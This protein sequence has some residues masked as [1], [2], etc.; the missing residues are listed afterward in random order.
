MQVVYLCVHCV[1]QNNNKHVWT[2]DLVL[3]ETSAFYITLIRK[4]YAIKGI[5]VKRW[6]LFKR[7]FSLH[8]ITFMCYPIN[9]SPLKTSSLTFMCYLIKTFKQISGKDRRPR[10]QKWHKDTLLKVVWRTYHLFF[11]IQKNFSFF[12]LGLN[13]ITW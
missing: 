13:A 4:A 1:T 11:D 9:K 8:S 2:R 12:W 5:K 6:K 7:T 3:V 10:K